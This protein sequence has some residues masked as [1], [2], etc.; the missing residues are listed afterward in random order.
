MSMTKERKIV[1]KSDLLSADAYIKSRKK[2]E[3]N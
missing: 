2:L 3:K 1:E